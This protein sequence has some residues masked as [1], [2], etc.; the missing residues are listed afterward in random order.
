MRKL[1]A[2]AF[3]AFL[4]ACSNPIAPSNDCDPAVESCEILP[5]SGG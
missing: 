3:I 1:F 5:D 2:L 4:G